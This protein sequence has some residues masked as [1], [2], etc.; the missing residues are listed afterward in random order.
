MED[1]VYL[2]RHEYNL[3]QRTREELMEWYWEENNVVGR[4]VKEVVNRVAIRFVEMVMRIYRAILLWYLK[5]M[6]ELHY[7]VKQLSLNWTGCYEQIF[8]SGM[9]VGS[10]K[11]VIPLYPFSLVA[12]STYEHPHNFRS[13]VLVQ[14]AEVHF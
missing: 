9:R 1:K 13:T 10:V 8:E 11:D 4:S 12:L 6:S 5:E 2:L 3:M 7:H 14:L